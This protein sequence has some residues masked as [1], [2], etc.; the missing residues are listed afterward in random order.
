MHAREV[1]RKEEE[2]RKIKT[3]RLQFLSAVNLFYFACEKYIYWCKKAVFFNFYNTHPSSGDPCEL[4]K[5]ILLAI[6]TMFN[7][8]FRFGLHIM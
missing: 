6:F 2:E 8:H 5:F 3:T 1:K 4:F 7:F